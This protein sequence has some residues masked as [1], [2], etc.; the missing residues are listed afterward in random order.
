MSCTVLDKTHK[1]RSI[2]FR[3]GGVHRERAE[4]DYKKRFRKRLNGAMTIEL[5]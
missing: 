5:D 1:W 3:D 2:W 4:Y